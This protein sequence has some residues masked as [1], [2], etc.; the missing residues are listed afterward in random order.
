M[1]R[2]IAVAWAAMVAAS[3]GCGTELP[4]GPSGNGNPPVDTTAKIV[5]IVASGD[6][7]MVVGTSKQY[8]CSANYD[9]GP[10]KNCTA[11]ASWGALPSTVVAVNAGVATALQPGSAQI[12]VTF[13][14][15][16]FALSVEVRPDLSAAEWEWLKLHSADGL[17]YTWRWDIG[18]PNQI[19]PIKVWAQTALLRQVAEQSAQ[20]WTARS[21]GKITFEYVA[22]SASGQIRVWNDP[23]AGDSTHPC[24]NTAMVLG[25]NH[26]FAGAKIRIRPGCENQPV[27]AHEFGHGLG[28]M[29]HTTT[30]DIMGTA[31]VVTSSTFLDH[32]LNGLYVMPAGT[33]L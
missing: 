23:I 14:G 15:K 6:P 28:L 16:S 26:Y 19:K 25:E 27:L 33:R 31:V 7:T 12:T 8:V 4:T 18:V 1:R 17:G 20:F 10:S 13:E 2:I 32:V 11:P 29:G 24:G 5:S 22:D 9:H 21:N 3:T 30:N